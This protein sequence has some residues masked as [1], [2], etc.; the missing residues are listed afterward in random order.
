M[1]R[2]HGIDAADRLGAPS[3]IAARRPPCSRAT[4][5]DRQAAVL[6]DIERG[7]RMFKRVSPPVRT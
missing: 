7:S 1:F 6:R 4:L 3:K 2:D 5:T